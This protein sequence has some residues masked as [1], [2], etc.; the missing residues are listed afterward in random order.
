M[1]ISQYLTFML[2]NSHCFE[3]SKISDSCALFDL[4]LVIYGSILSVVLIPPESQQNMEC[5]LFI[6][7]NILIVE[8]RLRTMFEAVPSRFLSI[9]LS[10]MYSILDFV[11]IENGNLVRMLKP[12]E[13]F[14]SS[15]VLKCEVTSH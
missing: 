6:Y 3:K 2:L 10:Y 15:H 12:L 11:S 9:E 7:I 14:G 1:K 5:K 4:K 8:F 13:T